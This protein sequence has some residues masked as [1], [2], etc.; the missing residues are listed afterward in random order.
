MNTPIRP[1]NILPRVIQ[2][3]MGVYISGSRL[4]R[5]VALAG[6]IGVVSA[7][8]IE[9]VI[10]RKLQLGDRN[11]ELARAFAA[12]PDKQMAQRVWKRYFDRKLPGQRLKTGP[13]WMIE[14]LGS[15]NS[16]GPNRRLVELTVLSSFSEI[17]QAKTGH[18]GRV[19]VNLM[20]KLQLPTLAY[21]YGA[22]LA[23]VDYVIVGAG[24][25][26]QYSGFIDALVQH[27]PAVLRLQATTTSDRGYEI[28]LDPSEFLTEPLPNLERP[29]FYPIVSSHVLAKRLLDKAGH[30]DGFI[31]EGPTAGGHNAPPRVGGV[32]TER[33]EPVYGERDVCNLDSMAA[34]GK[35]FY[36]AGGYGTP[37]GLQE[38]LDSGAAGIQVGTPFALCQES[39]L[40]PSLKMRVLGHIA[41]G[42]LDVI[43]SQTHSPTGLPFQ[44]VNITGSLSHED[45]YA[46]RQRI[47]DVGLLVEYYERE[48]GSL[49]QRCPAEPI[50][51]YVKKGGDP[52]NTA[53]RRCLCNG[54]LATAGCATIRHPGTEEAST[55]R[56]IITLGKDLRPV[57]HFL[58][59]GRPQFTAEDV[60]HYIRGTDHPI[61]A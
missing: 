10:V 59:R 39:G 49:G 47:C 30:I 25:P 42:T 8:G 29:Q 2:G 18:S 54:L 7:T 45:V 4:A 35:P 46:S 57:E 53:Q 19:G 52:V 38:A 60:I 24:I 58:A 51:D 48:D 9:R 1:E 14:R 20:Q 43:S 15:L 50:E 44:T 6:E 3:G 56:P 26:T 33:G 55:E 36:L 11:G 28:T 34:L 13:M 27:Q 21:L 23:G 16:V 17:W 12:F 61:T 5:A 31:V 40:I 41:R 32:F 37:E 22:L